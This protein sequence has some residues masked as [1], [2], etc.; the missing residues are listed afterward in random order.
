M[1]SRFS[2]LVFALLVFTLNAEAQYI[3]RSEPQPYSCPIICQGGTLFLRIFQVQNIPAGSRVQ[4]LVSNVNGSFASGTT[5]LEVSRYTFNQSTWTPGP[6]VFSSNVSELFAEFTIPTNFPTGSMYT[7]KI[8]SSSGY[9][10]ADQFQCGGSNY[11][12]VTPYVPPLAAVAQTAEGTN[13]WIGHV[14]TWTATT[15]S[16]LNTPSLI[17]QQSFFSSSNYKG[18]ILKDALSFDVPLSSSGSVPGTWNDGTSIDCGTTYA[19]NFSLRLLRKE[20]FTPGLYKIEIAGDDGIRLSIDGG[21]TWILD[22]FIE[23]AYSGSFRTTATNSPNGICL[24]GAIHLVIEYFQRPADSRMTINFVPISTNAAINVTASGPLE[25][26]PGQS[27]TLT[28]NPVPSGLVWSNG[29]TTSSI[30]V[31]TAGTYYATATNGTSCPSSSDEFV[32]TQAATQGAL[33]ITPA[34]PLTL[35]SG[36]TAVLTAQAGVTNLL[37]STGATTPTLT[38]SQSGSYSATG[39]SAGGCALTSNTVVV[40]VGTGAGVL[41]VTPSGPLSFCQGQSVTL[42]AASGFTGY[43]WSNSQTGSSI[44]VTHAGNYTVS[45]QSSAGCTATSPVITVTVDNQGGVLTVTPSGDITICDGDSVTLSAQTGYS[46]YTWS[47]GATT[48]TITVHET[49]TYSVA[50]NNSSG[51]DAASGDIL[52]T[53]VQPPV[54]SFTYQQQ[55][56]YSVAFTNTSTSGATYFWDFNNGFTATATNVDFT[57]PFE[58]TYPVTLI[59]SNECGTDTFSTDVIVIKQVGIHELKWDIELTVMPNPSNGQFNIIT[60]LKQFETLNFSVYNSVGQLISS[61]NQIKSGKTSILL[62]L[63]ELAGGIYYLRI[64]NGTSQLTKKLIKN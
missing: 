36:Q 18:H 38:V 55:T 48:R 4:A 52:V 62:N 58:G 1:I 6:Y 19:N 42:T 25:L 9:T 49:G 31:N 21:V 33:S 50:G 46:G 8:K 17:N 29:A 5:T 61:E 41:D 44:T 14:Y 3:S 24:S 56:G 2:L 40:T 10:S 51:C 35:C 12:T 43:V 45:A 37:W 57:Y 39:T 63:S 22:S 60:Q 27:A 54:A 47:T 53:V 11:I 34:G 20:V 32:V 59:V 23:Q 7:V 28:A 15:G 26:C 13:Q 16:I 30:T 64:S